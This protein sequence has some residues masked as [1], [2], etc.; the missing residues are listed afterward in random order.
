VGL[1]ELHFH[2]ASNRFWCLSFSVNAID[3]F[4]IGCA[5]TGTV[6]KMMIPI[7]NDFVFDTK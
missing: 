7:E 6:S 2:F 5:N 4:S 3:P 1:F